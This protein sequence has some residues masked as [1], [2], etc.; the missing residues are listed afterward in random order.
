M[1]DSLLSIGFGQSNILNNVVTGGQHNEK[2][3]CE[4]FG[5]AYLFLFNSFTNS[6]QEPVEYKSKVICSP[7]L[8]EYYLTFSIEGKIIFDTIRIIDI[9]GRIVKTISQPRK[10]KIDVHTLAPGMYTIQCFSDGKIYEAKFIK[11]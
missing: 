9:N 3:W 10:D 8:V 2:L 11:K 7:N 6:I 5:E 4:A 1:K